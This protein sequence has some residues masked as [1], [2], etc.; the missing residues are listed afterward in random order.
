MLKRFIPLAAA[1]LTLLPS[2]A[3]PQYSNR[4]EAI[5]AQL[6]DPDSKYVVVVCHRGDWRNWPENSIPAIESII[7]MGADMME[8]DLKMTSDSVLVLSHDATV[9]RCTN[10][11]KVFKDEPGKSPKVSDLTY[12]EIQRLSLIRT[13]G[14]AAIDTLRMPT[15]EEALLCC[16]DRICVNVDQG[17]QYYDQV[18]EI[19][20]RLGV[21]DQILIKGKRP[22]EVVSAHEAA[23]EHNMMYMPIVDIQKPA[24]RKLFASYI[25]GGVV[26]LAYEVCWQDNSDGAFDEACAKIKAQGSKIWVN[27]IWAQLCGGDGNDDD[28]AFQAADPSEV[29]GQYISRGVSIIQTDRPELLISYLAKTGH[30]RAVRAL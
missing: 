21:T 22:I 9:L 20:E 17:Y 1:L 15:L 4:A 6:H 13:H 8:L 24:G 10:F 14:A 11:G 12:A 26:P 29:Y 27:T 7:A 25:D 2:C 3:S 30:H 16:K 18:L 28:A 19:T 5:A 23:Y